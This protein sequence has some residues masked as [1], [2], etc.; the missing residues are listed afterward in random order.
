MIRLDSGE[1]RQSGTLRRST[2][3]VYNDVCKEN[4]NNDS[5]GERLRPRCHPYLILS[6]DRVDVNQNLEKE[7]EPSLDQPLPFEGAILLNSVFWA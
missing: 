4:Y 2:V 3:D 5:C 6:Q 1:I 7:D